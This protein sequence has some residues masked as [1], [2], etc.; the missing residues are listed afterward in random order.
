MEKT[1]RQNE[2]RLPL[3]RTASVVLFF[4]L[5]L[6]RLTFPE[7]DDLLLGLWRGFPVGL[8]GQTW[9]PHHAGPGFFAVVQLS[10]LSLLLGLCTEKTAA[11][12]RHRY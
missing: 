9:H 2:E 7:L 3:D 6:L 10:S 11:H 5:S 4:Y 8:G 1:T 12:T